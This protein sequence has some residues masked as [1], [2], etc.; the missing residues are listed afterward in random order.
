VSHF[1]LFCNAP[2]VAM[3]TAKQHA[4]SKKMRTPTGVFGRSSTSTFVSFKY[5]PLGTTT[6]VASLFTRV[7]EVHRN[8]PTGRVSLNF[9]GP[10][11]IAINYKLS[12]EIA[13][14]L[15]A[16]GVQTAVILGIFWCIDQ[17]CSLHVSSSLFVM[18]SRGL[19]CAAGV[20]QRQVFAVLQGNVHHRGPS[21]GDKPT[22]YG[23]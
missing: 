23:R 15:G 16:T 6:T 8:T 11:G 14:L 12:Q 1:C 9:D 21:L 3:S 20:P 10:A 13:R 22:F 2:E 18:L 5:R 17:V 4:R 19:W 7:A